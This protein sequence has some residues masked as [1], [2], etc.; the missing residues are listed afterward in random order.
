MAQ[1]ITARVQ[2]DSVTAEERIAAL[3]AEYAGQSISPHR[4]EVIQRRALAIAMECMDVEIV[5]ARQ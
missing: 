4:M 2:F 3:V 5:L 1:P